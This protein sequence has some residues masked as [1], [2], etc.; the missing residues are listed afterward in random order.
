[1][2]GRGR[3]GFDKS[4]LAFVFFLLENLRKNPKR[5]VLKATCAADIVIMEGRMDHRYVVLN[6]RNWA[7]WKFQM[8]VILKSKKLY[9]IVTEGDP[10]EKKNLE[11]WE[12][13]DNKAQELLV[14]RVDEQV[15]SY[16]SSCTTSQQMWEKLCTLYEPSSQV[17]VHL[18]QQR[19]FS[20]TF[21]EPMMKFISKL[22]EITNQLRTM[23]E[24][25]SDKMIV[26]KTLMALPEKYRHFVSAWESV[27]EHNQTMKELTSRLLIEEERSDQHKP[28][29]TTSAFV[30]RTNG[31]ATEGTSA[32]KCFMCGK[33]GHYKRDCKQR[34]C[35]RCNKMGH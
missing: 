19:F 26:T 18:V 22:D 5:K 31:F 14:T 32:R 15:M 12:D 3:K 28:I 2:A 10:L 29:P 13:K 16:L 9:K 7:A 21:E 11:S 25:P 35:F 4:E 20:L 1:M 6:G 17:S 33:L 24:A 8:T 27:P 23:G 34:K 30:S